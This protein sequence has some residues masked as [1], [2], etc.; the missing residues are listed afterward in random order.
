MRRWFNRIVIA[1]AVRIS[2]REQDLA[3]AGSNAWRVFAGV[4]VCRALC[5]MMHPR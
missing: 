5:S 3:I 2:H 4:K 1:A